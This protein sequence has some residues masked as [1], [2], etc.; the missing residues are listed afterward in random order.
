MRHKVS[1]L[2]ELPKAFRQVLHAMCPTVKRRNTHMSNLA[3]AMSPDP[4]QGR[5]RLL[6]DKGVITVNPSTGRVTINPE[7]LVL[8][9]PRGDAQRGHPGARPSRLT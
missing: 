1:P 3:M 7:R 6:E 2:R 8:R 9:P 5:L 4:P